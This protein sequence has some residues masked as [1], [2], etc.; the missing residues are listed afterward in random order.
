MVDDPTQPAIVI[1][2]IGLDPTRVS[3]ASHSRLTRVSL[4]L[5]AHE[6]RSGR[7]T[8]KRVGTDVEACTVTAQSARGGEGF[9][10][11]PTRVLF[12]DDEPHLLAG[13]RR[14][15]HTLGVGWQMRFAESGPQALEVLG[16][17]PIDAV[18][19]DMRMPG[20]DGAHLLTQVQ[21][22]HPGTVRIVLSG[23]AERSA[24]LAAA[25]AA[26]QFLAK[27]C[28][29]EAIVAV[30]ERA[31]D[32]RR[33][34][35]DPALRELMG[36]IT[37]LPMLPSV[38]HELLAATERL[39]CTVHTVAGILSRDT[40]TCAEVLK[41][42]NSAF[43]GI[44]RRIE[45]VDQ[46][47]AMLGLETIKAL[48][49]TGT[50]FRPAPDLPPAIGRAL[51]HQAL[52]RTTVIR[53]I[54]A[55]E[56]WPPAEVTAVAL[57]GMLLEV[58]ALVLARGRPEQTRELET[59]ARAQAPGRHLLEPVPRRALE[60]RHYGCSVPEAS[61]Y[62]LGLWGFSPHVV[63]LVASQPVPVTTPGAT[64][65][66]VLIT[67]ADGAV[68]CPSAPPPDSVAGEH[69]D[70]AGAPVVCADRLAQWHIACRDLLSAESSEAERE[71]GT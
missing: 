43:F 60:R 14:S 11:S 32:L 56:G 22:L 20:M 5:S 24:V 34:L 69:D 25:A 50:A 7:S 49:V 65:S 57:A 37:H 2:G 8:L 55:Q 17:E 42:T 36:G 48:V 41:L 23:E 35:A 46:A 33:T 58:G 4:A 1:P 54:A 18:V 31:L 38:F 62:L 12:V 53:R 66:E 64:P 68:S 40:A 15:L 51:Q 21:R 13:L 39:D 30:V 70:R 71:A 63:H 29:S 52:Q 27:P 67:V 45:S 61:A 10:T 9:V 44:P 26:H 19:S 28:D 3:L 6:S 47:V 16:S 59:E